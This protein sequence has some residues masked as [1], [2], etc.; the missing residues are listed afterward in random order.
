MTI[1]I[2]DFIFNGPFWLGFVTALVL[3]VII[4]SFAATRSGPHF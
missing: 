4:A 1:T 3:T 2:P